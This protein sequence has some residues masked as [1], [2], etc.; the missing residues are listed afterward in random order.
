MHSLAL[1]PEVI[2]DEY[3][4][5]GKRVWEGPTGIKVEMKL[6]RHHSRPDAREE[7]ILSSIV[8]LRE[9]STEKRHA[10]YIK[11]AEYAANRE[12]RGEFETEGTQA[13]VLDERPHR[14]SQEA[15]RQGSEKGTGDYAR[16]LVVVVL[17]RTNKK[18]QS[19]NR[20]LGDYRAT[21][22]NTGYQSH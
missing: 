6:C 17:W 11:E 5:E 22:R 1:E 12:K 10:I 16:K 8:P 18:S 9:G 15:Q 20:L 19:K 14:R 7:P 13:Q 2:A 4:Y 3:Q 21:Y